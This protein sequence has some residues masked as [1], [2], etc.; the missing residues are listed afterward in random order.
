MTLDPILT[1]PPAIQIHVFAA[2]PAT[3]LGPFVIYRKRRD[4][5]HKSLGYA[6]VVTMAVMAL[7]SFFI[8]GWRIIGPFGPIH[9]IS[10]F[11][12]QGLISGLIDARAARI[13]EHKATMQGVYWW[14]I[15]FAGLLTLMPGRRLNEALFA[16]HPETGYWV[17]AAGL[18]LLI[19]RWWLAQEGRA[20]SV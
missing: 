13:T 5:L 1:A 6:W 20:L 14:G 15:G 9:L 2:I 10:I 4:L 19:A 16:S 12:L 8:F 7:S 17:I 3:L 18:L 11:V